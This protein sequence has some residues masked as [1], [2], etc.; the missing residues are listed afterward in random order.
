MSYLLEITNIEKSYDISKTQ[1]QTVLRGVEAGFFKGELVA[2]LGESGSGKSTLINILGGLDTTYTGSVIFKGKYLRDYSEKEMD[3]YRKKNIGMVFQNY[4]LIGHMN[5][6][7]NVEIAMTMSDINP[8]ERK[9]HAMDLLKMVGL[10]KIA[11]KMPSQLSGGQKQRV[12]IARAL[13][14]DPD[15]ILADEPTGALDKEATDTVLAIL[16][17]IVKTGKLV[18]IVTHSQKIADNCSRIIQI[19]DG[20]VKVDKQINTIDY[21]KRFVNNPSQKH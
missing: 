14:N 5:L 13:A 11:D 9:Q 19:D 21:E 18:I 15:I 17:E 8:A 10:D 16:T 20:I 6:L 1:K 12:A 4:Q 7:E 2:I 3:D